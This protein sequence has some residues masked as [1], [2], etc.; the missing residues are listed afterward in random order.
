FARDPRCGIEDRFGRG[1]GAGGQGEE[2]EAEDGDRDEGG[3]R[4]GDGSRN[5]EYG[6]Y[7]RRGTAAHGLDAN[8]SSPRSRLC[9][10]GSSGL[11]SRLVPLRAP[12]AALPARAVV[13]HEDPSTT[14]PPRL[15]L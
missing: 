1:Q 13:C 2:D 7:E 8:A 10:R 6:P 5:G 12:R 11:E 14:A 4:D 9:R 3:A 15:R